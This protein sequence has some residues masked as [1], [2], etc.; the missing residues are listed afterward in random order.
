MW[1]HV[2]IVGHDGSHY[3]LTLLFEQKILKTQQLKRTAIEN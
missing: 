2:N 3:A 1:G